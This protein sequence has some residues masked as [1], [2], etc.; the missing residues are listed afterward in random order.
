MFYLDEE[1]ELKAK[2]K[3]ENIQKQY[4]ERLQQNRLRNEKKPSSTPKK[5]VNRNQK[6]KVKKLKKQTE[7]LERK[8]KILREENEKLKKQTQSLKEKYFTAEQERIKWKEKASLLEEAYDEQQQRWE[9]ERQKKEQ[10]ST[11]P[12]NKLRDLE[13][14][15]KKEQTKAQDLHK[16]VKG[17]KQHIKNLEYRLTM[18]RALRKEERN[19]KVEKELE[20]TKKERT[21]YKTL[22]D[23]LVRPENVQQCYVFL[24]NYL[25]EETVEEYLIKGKNPFGEL[26]EKISRTHKA[27]RQKRHNEQMQ[28]KTR[29]LKK[30]KNLTVKQKPDVPTQMGYVSRIGHTWTFIG[31][32]KEQ[33]EVVNPHEHRDLTDEKPV[34]VSLLPDQKVKIVKMYE[35][36]PIRFHH[37]GKRVF[38]HRQKKK[39][40]TYTYIGPFHV[41]VVGS[42]FQSAYVARLK[43]HGLHVEWH[44]PH[45]ESYQRLDEKHK[46]SEITIVC[47]S[48]VPHAVLDHINEEEEKVELIEHDREETIVARVRY[49]AIQLG[50]LNHSF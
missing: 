11:S 18:D 48:H 5:E 40:K 17:Q 28:V 24:C 30:K 45:E 47:T 43:K 3:K 7:Q 25:K 15:L 27:L 13:K 38:L 6:A 23:A 9:Q 20:R 14:A 44:N 22:Y 42:R 31:L 41:L 4:M 19:Q 39:S 8:M 50:L 2:N 1:E 34:Q 26:T 12:Q 29:P 16:K 33:F 21:H 49:A 36:E 10:I 37:K 35:A 46:K 32:N